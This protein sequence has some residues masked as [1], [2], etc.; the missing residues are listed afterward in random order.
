MSLVT[1][2]LFLLI[3]AQRV[4][5]REKIGLW[6][7]NK[8]PNSPPTWWSMHWDIPESSI[9]THKIAT[10][11]RIEE[12]VNSWNLKEIQTPSH[13]ANHNPDDPL[14]ASPIWPY[15]TAKLMGCIRAIY[16][17]NSWQQAS[18]LCDTQLTNYFPLIATGKLVSK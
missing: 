9:F 1:F 7:R 12:N 5:H 13:L 10:I 17:I 16:L 15:L 6:F 3:S 18:C 11:W 2:K 4:G 8:I 14:L